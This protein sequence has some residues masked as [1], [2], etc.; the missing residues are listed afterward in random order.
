M[1]TADVDAGELR[2]TSQV[3]EDDQSG[4]G[5]LDPGQVL[6]APVI[7]IGAGRTRRARFDGRRAD[8]AAAQRRAQASAPPCQRVPS[9]R[10]DG[11]D[12]YDGAAS[13]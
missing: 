3:V 9:E 12:G 2:I 10:C 1:L 8:T 6:L 11:R 7:R 13:R 4:D 5:A